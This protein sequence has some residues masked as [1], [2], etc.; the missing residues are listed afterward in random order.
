[1]SLQ[2]RKLLGSLCLPAGLHI[3]FSEL[4]FTTINFPLY[5]PATSQVRPYDL[6]QQICLFLQSHD[7]KS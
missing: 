1:M 5:E 7:F 4:S 3:R 2:H 6:L